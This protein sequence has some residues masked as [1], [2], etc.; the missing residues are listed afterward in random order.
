MGCL[1]EAS[2]FG[3]AHLHYC[4]REERFTGASEVVVNYPGCGKS[5]TTNRLW[6]FDWPGRR[7]PKGL[8]RNEDLARRGGLARSLQIHEGMSI[9]LLLGVLSVGWTAYELG[10]ATQEEPRVKA[11]DRHGRPLNIRIVS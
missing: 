4:C 8:D 6:G 11:W 5:Q 7:R 10:R 3:A 9:F 1:G 2:G